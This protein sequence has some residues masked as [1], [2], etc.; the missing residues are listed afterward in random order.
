MPF[1]ITVDGRSM[2]T[3]DFTLDE[4]TA[5]EAEVGESWDFVVMAPYKTARHATSLIKHFLSRQHGP[6]EASKR[7]G[8]MTFKQVLDA[9]EPVEDDRPKMHQDGVPVVD[10]KAETAEPATTSS[11]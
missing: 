6:E 5:I 8:A 9:M 2:L 4:L 3:E 7:A 1:R 11:S 10:P